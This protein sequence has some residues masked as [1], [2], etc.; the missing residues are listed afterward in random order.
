VHKNDIRRKY[1]FLFSAIDEIKKLH[2]ST[3]ISAIRK[4]HKTTKNNEIKFVVCLS[5]QNAPEHTQRKELYNIDYG[6]FFSSIYDLLLADALALFSC[7]FSL[8]FSPPI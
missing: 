5:V 2:K 8:A 4:K 1:V 3:Q 6:F 7:C